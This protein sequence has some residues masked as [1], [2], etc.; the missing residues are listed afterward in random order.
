MQDQAL[1]RFIAKHNSI[2]IS[3]AFLRYRRALEKKWCDATILLDFLESQP[4]HLFC[5]AH[6]LRQN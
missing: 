3:L 1:A 2:L 6:Q 5:A 4:Y